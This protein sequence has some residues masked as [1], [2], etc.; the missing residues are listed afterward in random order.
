MLKIRHY[1]R[2]TL[3]LSGLIFF[4][5]CGIIFHLVPGLYPV[6]LYITDIFLLIAN[7][8]VLYSLLSQSREKRLIPWAI[9]AFL[10]TFSL[11]AAGV[12]TGMVFGSYR[13]GDTMKVQ[14]LEVPVIIAFNWIIL[15]LATSSLVRLVSSKPWITTTLAAVVIVLFD[16][17]MEPVAVMLDYWTWADGRI[18][19][20]NYLAWFLIAWTL[21][22]FIQFGKFRLRSTLLR[23]Y[24][25]IQLVFFLA[26]RFL[27]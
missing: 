5:G 6:T 14:L 10:L 22:A 2:D 19:L 9:V 26:L 11:E 12:H 18:P 8:L 1:S 25:F 13:Y 21:S 7:S 17:V 4:F 27:Y 15:I 23:S 20:Q 24:F 3:I 16:Y